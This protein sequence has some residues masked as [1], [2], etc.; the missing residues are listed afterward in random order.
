MYLCPTIEETP[1]TSAST[2]QVS[3]LALAL[4]FNGAK[5]LMTYKEKLQPWCI[6]RNLPDMRSKFIARFRS[7]SDA[8]GHMQLLRANNP[9]TSYQVIFNVTPK[10]AEEK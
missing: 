10:Q 6:I 5:L 8:Q 9:T 4:L 1:E 7:R 2:L 3:V